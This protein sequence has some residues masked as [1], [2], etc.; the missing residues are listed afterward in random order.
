MPFSKRVHII[1]GRGA[2]PDDYWYPWV[3]STLEQSGFAVTILQLPDPDKPKKSTWM[4]ALIPLVGELDEV[5]YL[6]GHSVG[7]QAVLRLLEGLPPG[8]MI[9]GTVLVAGWVSVP[10]WEG[11][12][13]TEKAVLN[14][15]LNPP[16]HLANLAAKSKKFTAIFSDDD[17]F[18]PK[19]NWEACE[20]QLKAKVIIKHHY[21]HFEAKVLR[22]LPEVTDAIRF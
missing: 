19:E 5:T 8:R 21:D 17:P 15:W 14:D 2:H 20:N 10:S 12:S 22:Q 16:L 18:V 9:G 7:C 11:R 4:N 3:R 6:I 1:P 13:E